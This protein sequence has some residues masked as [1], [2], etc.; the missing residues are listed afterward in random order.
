MRMF[1]RGEHLRLAPKAREALRIIN[2]CIRQDLDSDIAP[3]P[4]IVRTVNLTHAACANER[5]DFICAEA[6]AGR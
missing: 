4:R 3:E 1:E 5:G 6:S 2:K